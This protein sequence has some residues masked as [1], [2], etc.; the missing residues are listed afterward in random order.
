MRVLAVDPGKTTGIAVWNSGTFS[1][2]AEEYELALDFVA[3]YIRDDYRPD[4]VVIEDFVITQ[5]TT[6]MGTANWRRGQELEFIGVARWWCKTTGVEF[7]L[8][9]PSQAKS[10]STDQKLKTYGWWSKG[11][12]HPRDATRHLMLYLVK[13][14]LIDPRSLV[15]EA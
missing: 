6:K 15:S 12:D 14:G 13:A 8:Q 10:F 11:V 9:T 5:R 3:S 4:V 1:A 2:W 7:V